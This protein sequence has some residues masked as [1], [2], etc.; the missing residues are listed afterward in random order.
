MYKLIV[1]FAETNSTR[2]LKSDKDYNKV[3]DACIVHMHFARQHGLHVVLK[4]H[5]FNII[6]DRNRVLKGY[7]ITG[8]K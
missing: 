7:R 6:D 8:V 4:E 1:A 3:L 2:V 5:G